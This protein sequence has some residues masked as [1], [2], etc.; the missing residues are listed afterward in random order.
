[1]IEIVS[2]QAG[3]NL[4]HL[5][6]LSQEYVDWMTAQVRERYP[7]INLHDFVSER[8]YED[9]RRKFPGKHVPPY[10]CLL[11]ALDGDEGAGCAA[12]GRLTDS[13]C[14][15]RTVYVRPAFRGTGVGRQ[16]VVA[17]LDEARKLGYST[18]R[19]DTLRFMEGAQKLYYSLGF[20]EIEPYVDI[21]PHLRKYLCFMEL[22]L[23]A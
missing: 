14:E 15:L 2:A 19:L 8:S 5:L 7:Q 12:L 22:R 16:L 13:I 17:S 20:V 4:E 6:S 10:G 11:V 3:A 21:P 9:V 18:V 1:M 23:G